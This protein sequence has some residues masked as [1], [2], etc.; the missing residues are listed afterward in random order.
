MLIITSTSQLYFFSN[1]EGEDDNDNSMPV[2]SIVIICI[3]GVILCGSILLGICNG[4]TVGSGTTTSN[5]DYNR[6]NN[7]HYNNNNNDSSSHEVARHDHGWFLSISLALGLQY[8]QITFSLIIFYFWQ[9]KNERN[10]SYSMNISS[11]YY[12]SK[13]LQSFF[14]TWGSNFTLWFCYFLISFFFI[15]SNFFP[16]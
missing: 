10:H 8:N 13:T 6:F 9:Q 4:G 16:F 3:V 14:F 15:G 7:N 5:D 1:I 11:S 2:W 12:Y